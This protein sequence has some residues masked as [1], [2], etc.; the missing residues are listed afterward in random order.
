MLNHYKCSEYQ[1]WL[2]KS[3]VDVNLEETKTNGFPIRYKR[4][5]IHHI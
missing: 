5:I 3:E 1:Q 4:F 2:D